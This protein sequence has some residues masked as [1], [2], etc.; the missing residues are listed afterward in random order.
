MHRATLPIEY[1]AAILIVLVGAFITLSSLYLILHLI[2]DGY[3][4]KNELPAL[5]SILGG[6]TV[7]CIAAVWSGLLVGGKL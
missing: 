5:L 2:E 6:N 3:G 1:R 7:I 4:F